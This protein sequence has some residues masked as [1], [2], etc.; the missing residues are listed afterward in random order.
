M[1]FCLKNLVWLIAFKCSYGASMRLIPMRMP[2]LSIVFVFCL[3]LMMNGRAQSVDS[4][5]QTSEES[6]T[7]LSEPQIIS[8]Q[9]SARSRK[10]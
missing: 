8:T 2:R 3:A 5:H 9:I 10:M 7:V 1:R 6:D 4:P